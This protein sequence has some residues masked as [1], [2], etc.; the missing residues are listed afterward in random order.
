MPPQRVLCF[1]NSWEIRI[2]STCTDVEEHV[3]FDGRSL[4]KAKQKLRC[5]ASLLFCPLDS[6]VRMEQPLMLPTMKYNKID[7]QEAG[8]EYKKC[9]MFIQVRMGPVTAYEPVDAVL[10]AL[11]SGD[12]FG[13]ILWGTAWLAGAMNG[14]DEKG[15]GNIGLFLLSTAKKPS[16]HFRKLYL[17]SYS[18]EGFWALKARSYLYVLEWDTQFCQVVT[19]IGKK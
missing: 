7:K 11:T 17:Y 6:S 12:D 13:Q 18:I 10:C 2:V 8:M 16:H 1:L 15:E 4:S 19:F 5:S 9:A 14:T 3:W